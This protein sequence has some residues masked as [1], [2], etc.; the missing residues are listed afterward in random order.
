MDKALLELA[1]LTREAAHLRELRRTLSRQIRDAEQRRDALAEVLGKKDRAPEEQ[2]R[3]RGGS[4]RQGQP[5]GSLPR[6]PYFCK[7][8]KDGAQ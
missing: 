2:P 1:T 3:A 6:C 8:K 5:G 4:H 7:C